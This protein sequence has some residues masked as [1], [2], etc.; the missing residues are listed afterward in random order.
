[1]TCGIRAIALP[2]S[3]TSTLGGAISS[4]TRPDARRRPTEARSIR[5]ATRSAAIGSA[6]VEAGGEH[7]DAGDRGGR[8]RVGVGE[9]VL[10]GA[11]D[12]ERRAVGLGELA[13]RDQVHD[14]AGERDDDHRPAA[15]I[16][17]IDQP[18][19]RA[20]GDEAREHEQRRAVRLRGEHL[21]PAEAEGDV[22]VR[23]P[24]DEPDHDEREEERAGVGQHVR[25]VGDQRERV[26]HDARDHLDDHERDD[27]CETGRQAALVR[28][29]RDRVDVPAWPW[30]WSWP[31]V[32][33]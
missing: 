26:G 31:T 4:S 25:G 2:I 11:L 29:L 32:R 33:E 9:E 15:R 18:F 5:A 13:R 17:R 7:D 30:L 20:E 21:H 22:P 1:M 6:R 28:I 24:S 10:V 3:S 8:E 19:D 23:G 27:Q 16:G 12:V 14:E